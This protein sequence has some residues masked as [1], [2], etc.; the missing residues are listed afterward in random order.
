[1][2]ALNEV[3][4]RLQRTHKGMLVQPLPIRTGLITSNVD[5]VTRKF[6]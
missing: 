6:D 5:I 3:F 2:R 4:D 1:M